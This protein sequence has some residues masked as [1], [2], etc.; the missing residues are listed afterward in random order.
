MLQSPGQLPHRVIIL[1]SAT[2]HNYESFI[3]MIPIPD[4]L[5]EEW[6]QGLA[7]LAALVAMFGG[8]GRWIKLNMLARSARIS[9]NTGM[10]IYD[11]SSLPPERD[12]ERGCFRRL[13]DSVG[14]LLL[15]GLLA[16]AIIGIKIVAFT[17][18][19]SLYDLPS[20]AMELIFKIKMRDLTTADGCAH[21]CMGA[22]TV[23][24]GYGASFIALGFS[25]YSGFRWG[26]ARGIIISCFVGCASG[27]ITDTMSLLVLI[28][29]RHLFQSDLVFMLVS[30]SSAAWIFILALLW[31]VAFSMKD[32]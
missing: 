10:I 3:D 24:I 15:A 13:A 20:E 6:L 22:F 8:L 18:F 4:F 28:S 16:P 23:F 17:T 5:S 7:A 1:S 27:V 9:K 31:I 21:G 14:T 19:L 32:I 12:T 29:E 11:Q 25:C 26:L 30:A 2:N